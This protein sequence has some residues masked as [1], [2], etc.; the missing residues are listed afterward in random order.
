LSAQAKQNE[1][2]QTILP[3]ESD[4]VPSEAQMDFDEKVAK[5]KHDMEQSLRRVRDL[6]AH[7]RAG[8]STLATSKIENQ[9]LLCSNDSVL[10]TFQ[11]NSQHI[12]ISDH[13]RDRFVGL[14]QHAEQEKKAKYVTNLAKCISS[15]EQTIL[16]ELAQSYDVDGGFSPSTYRALLLHLS[17]WM[18]TRLHR[19]KNLDIVFSWAFHV[20]TKK[21]YA[22]C[23]ATAENRHDLTRLVTSFEALFENVSAKCAM[24]NG[25]GGTAYADSIGKLSAELL[26]ARD[27]STQQPAKDTIGKMTDVLDIANIPPQNFNTANDISPSPSVLWG[28]AGKCGFKGSFDLVSQH[29]KAC[30]LSN[31]MGRRQEAR[32]CIE[33]DMKEAQWMCEYKCG[34]S[35]RFKDVEVHEDTCTKNPNRKMETARPCTTHAKVC[36]GWGCEFECGFSSSFQEVEEHEKSCLMSPTKQTS[37]DTS[38]AADATNEASALK[39]NVPKSPSGTFGCEWDC[40]FKDPFEITPEH[41]KIRSL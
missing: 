25:S 10:A 33:N 32:P 15:T 21:K 36:S 3:L 5:I 2:E 8:S 35:S 7:L 30:H 1:G 20:R 34:Y 29:E 11:N 37:S 27:A 28:C 38:V 9:I 4:S 23:V 26:P 17:Q 18:R 13:I 41:E 40:G 24:P 19:K 6:G 12:L 31:S 16:L 22:R 39:E 14:E